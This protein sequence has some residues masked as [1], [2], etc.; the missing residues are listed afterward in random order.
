LPDKW[1]KFIENEGD[2]VIRWNSFGK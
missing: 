2:D 1:L